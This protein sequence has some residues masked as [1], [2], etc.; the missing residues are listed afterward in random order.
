MHDA[1]AALV[2]CEPAS[3]ELSVIN[4]RVRIQE[5]KLLDIDLAALIERHNAIARALVR[6]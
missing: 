6:G 4:G 5:G 1:L 3:V 2:F